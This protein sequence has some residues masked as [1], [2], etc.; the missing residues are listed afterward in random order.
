MA[1][2]FI[3][4]EIDD[5][6]VLRLLDDLTKRFSNLTPVMKEI[7]EIVTESVQR[8]FE[9]HRSPEGVPWEPLAESTKFEKEKKGKNAD[10]ILILTRILMGSIH[11]EAYADHVDVGTDVV[12]AAIH[13]FGGETGRGNKTII[14]ER[15]FLGVREEDWPEIKHMLV[16]ELFGDM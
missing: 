5:K 8:N 2:A 10:D 13:Q 11:P 14:P 9:E 3:D 7:G 16:N 4:V 15:P 12:Y 6:E 1:G